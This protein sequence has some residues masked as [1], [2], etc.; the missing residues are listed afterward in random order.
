MK[1]FL[2]IVARDIICKYGNNLSHIAIVFPNKRASLFMNKQLAHLVDKPLWSPAYITISELFRQHSTLQVADDIKLICDLHKVFN[3]CTGLNES[4]DKFYGWGQLLLTDFDDIDKNMA[5]AEKVFA[6]LKDIHELDDVSYLSDE[7]KEIL[8]KFFSNFS[9]KH[10][11][12]LKKRFLSLW[13]HFEDIYK[14]YNKTLSD[15]GYAYEGALYRKVVNDE[16]VNFNYDTYLFIGFNMMQKV[17][18]QLLDRLKKQ[19]RAKFYW[20]FD[21]YYMQKNNGI[22]YEAGTYIRQYLEYYPNELDNNDA[23]IYDNLCQQKDIT[24]ISATTENIQAHYITDWL[25]TNHRLEEGC[26]TAI[27]MADENLLPTVIHCLPPNTTKV[28]ITTG[29]PLAQSPFSSLITQLIV[30]QATGHKTGTDRY[31]L[32]YINLVLHHPYMRFISQKYNEL[33]TDLNTHKRYYP[34]RESLSL[35][36]GLSLLFRNL[37]IQ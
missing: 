16:N 30:M 14:L 23:D 3:T 2:E 32:H 8:E 27:V 1:T 36:E 15:Q 13:S 29:Y 6:N 17:E 10:N 4:L 19:G 33:I 7:Q 26:H 25:N 18:L 24:Y 5:D 35:D 31:R 22:L 20:D 11:S 21:K 28:N 37:D 12:E 9:D 34:T